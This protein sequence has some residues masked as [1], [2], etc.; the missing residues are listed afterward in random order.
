MTLKLIGK[1]NTENKKYGRSDLLSDPILADTT[2]FRAK[3]MDPLSKNKFPLSSDLA[4]LYKK[5]C[6]RPYSSLI[7]LLPHLEHRIH[8]ICQIE[9][10]TFRGVYTQLI[11]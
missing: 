10:L 2:R 8:L 9:V 5:I 6:S 11:T 4:A 7:A 3:L 1:P